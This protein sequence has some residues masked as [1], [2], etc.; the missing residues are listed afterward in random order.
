MEARGPLPLVLASGSPRRAALLES[1][2][3]PFE[4]FDPRDD[5]PI[6]PGGPRERVQAHARF[7]AAVGRRKHPERLVL[8][9]D[10]VVWLDGRAL[11]KPAG[12]AEAEA[13][14]RELAGRR[15]EVWTG[16]CLV[17]PGER[18]F[19][20]ADRAVVAFEPIP[21]AGLQAYLNRGEWSGKAGS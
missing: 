10:T 16:V 20:Q 8:A 15:H 18:V 2:G 5:G 3:I 11:G 6:P 14:L 9:A 21:E 1:A 19:E 12:R 4:A 13:M 7:K 17:A